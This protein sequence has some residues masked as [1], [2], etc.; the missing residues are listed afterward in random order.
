MAH[1]K[2]AG[3]RKRTTRPSSPLHL[4]K[5]TKSL[6]CIFFLASSLDRI[7][8]NHGPSLYCQAL[9]LSAKFTSEISTTKLESVGKTQFAVLDG[10]E[11]KSVQSI[12]REQRQQTPKPLPTTKY[13]YMSVLAGKDEQNRRIVA[14]QCT[15]SDGSSSV[16]YEDS[17]AVIP[18]HVS[19][20]DAISTYIASLSSIVCALPKVENIGGGGDESSVAISGKAVVLGSGDLACFSAEGLASLGIEVFLVNNKGSASVRK[21]IGKRKCDSNSWFRFEGQITHSTKMW[22]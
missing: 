7:L 5:L 14:M 16:V 8:Y 17:I 12:L 21:N 10:A 15:E 4:T 18:N 1:T 20:E 2:M 6:T 19:D 9:S 13:G 22:C 3:I 11:W